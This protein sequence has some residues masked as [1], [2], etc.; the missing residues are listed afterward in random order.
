MAA[1]AF[2]QLQQEH[3]QGGDDVYGTLSTLL[4]V[5]SAWMARCSN[6]NADA[7]A[8]RLLKALI[9]LYQV[10]CEHDDDDPVIQ[11][12]FPPPSSFWCCS[13]S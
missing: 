10:A 11:P 5:S 6:L 4:L 8:K 12:C 7:S 2:S 13:V 9:D 3:V 1:F